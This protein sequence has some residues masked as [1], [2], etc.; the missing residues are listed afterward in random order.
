[1]VFV[2]TPLATQSA[3]VLRQLK[4]EEVPPGLR[5]HLPDGVRENANL[6]FIEHD[7]KIMPDADGSP[8]L[9]ADGV[10]IGVNLY[11]G[12]ETKRGYA[13]S[14]AVLSQFLTERQSQPEAVLPLRDA[15]AVRPNPPDDP[16]PTNPPMPTDP[17]GEAFDGF[18]EFEK[19]QQKITE[20]GYRPQTREQYAGMQVFAEFLTLVQ[21]MMDQE[22]DRNPALRERTQK[23]IDAAIEKLRNAP[24]PEEGEMARINKLGLENLNSTLE[25]DP[26]LFLY[27]KCVLRSEDFGA[28]SI[29]DSPAFAFEVIGTDDLIAMPIAKG[30][31]DIEKGSVWLVLGQRS[32]E[33]ITVPTEKPREAR[34]VVSKYILGK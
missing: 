34:I 11:A 1:L 31:G 12:P 27:C 18:A 17:P 2:A 23:V 28:R 14:A 5:M 21:T 16:P 3:K 4:G 13:L 22:P 29:N 32:T 8:L 20:F 24:W 9:D 33:K 15:V 6:N 10:L 30:G 7:A 25:A 26:G 19:I